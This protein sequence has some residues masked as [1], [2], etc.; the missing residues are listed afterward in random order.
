[1]PSERRDLLLKVKGNSF[2]FFIRN[3]YLYLVGNE[4][5]PFIASAIGSGHRTNSG[6]TLND[7]PKK[8][9]LYN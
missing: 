8:V 2:I 5:K 9:Q 4:S 1:M 7:I 6:G 3:S